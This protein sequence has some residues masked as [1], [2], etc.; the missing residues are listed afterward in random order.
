MVKMGGLCE[1]C[2]KGDAVN[3]C[4]ECGAKICD[5]CTKEVSYEEFHPGYRMKGES[6]IGAMSEGVV[7]KKLCL[8]CFEEVDLLG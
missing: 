7:R 2:G 5:S 8:K 1:L 4:S 6:F 3:E